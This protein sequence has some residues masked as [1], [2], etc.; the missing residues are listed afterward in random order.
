M[1]PATLS[2]SILGGLAI[3]ALAADRIHHRLTRPARLARLNAARLMETPSRDR[4]Y[5][6]YRD[7]LDLYVVSR[8]HEPGVPHQWDLSRRRELLESVTASSHEEAKAHFAEL[9]RDNP[10]LATRE[11]DH[12]GYV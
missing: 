4:V 12:G 3:A 9:L 6:L 10:K 5:F 8:D 11:V 1:D 2:V 7:G